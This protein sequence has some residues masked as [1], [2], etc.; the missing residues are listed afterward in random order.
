MLLENHLFK[1][2]FF[3]VVWILCLGTINSNITYIINLNT[4]DYK[5]SVNNLFILINTFRF[6]TPFILLPIILTFILKN[7]IKFDKIILIYLCYA[8]WQLIALFINTIVEE[9]NR[10][11]LVLIDHLQIAIALISLIIISQITSKIDLR[12]Y[13]S[14]LITSLLIIFI[15]C[16]YFFSK[17]IINFNFY[18]SSYFYVSSTLI[19]ETQFMLQ[20]KPRITGL[21]RMTFLILTFLFFLFI[22]K[23][24]NKKISVLIF[25]GMFICNLIIWGA[26]SRGS[27]FGLLALITIYLF[28][29]KDKFIRKIFLSIL[30]FALPIISY[31]S[32]LLLVK[33][34][35]QV[36]VDSAKVDSAKVD[37]RILNSNQTHDVNTLTSGRIAIWKRSLEI[38]KSKNI[39]LGLGPQA[40]RLILSEDVGWGKKQILDNNA[41]NIFV[42]S[43]LS[44]GIVGIIL[45]LSIYL[46]IFKRILKENFYFKKLNKKNYF[47]N[48]GIVGILYLLT[49]GM[50]ENSISLFSI[51]S[52]FFLIFYF[53]T[54]EKYF[55][56]NT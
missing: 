39:I 5:F 27:L 8:I 3:I 23:N 41:S 35:P 48:T 17:I 31:E 10:D 45:I 28:C 26:Q 20:S 14:L 56:Q 7:K 11:F 40:D 36:E 54:K 44:S 46:K 21:A 49:R 51:D 32:T 1:K 29:I 47:F 33:K 34:N 25:I 18:E 9:N 22:S 12:L 2:I 16:F 4:F 52:C 50:F 38:I 53:L 24:L 37:N 55:N 30:I 15:V 13:K 19:P 43:Y 6:F 42:Y